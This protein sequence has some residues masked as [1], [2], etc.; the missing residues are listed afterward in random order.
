MCPLKVKKFKVSSDDGCEAN[1]G[2]GINPQSF[3][4]INQQSMPAQVEKNKSCNLKL[5]GRLRHDIE[6]LVAEVLIMIRYS[7]VFCAHM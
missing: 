6:L 5:D 7:S 4:L 1:G 3:C 2:Q